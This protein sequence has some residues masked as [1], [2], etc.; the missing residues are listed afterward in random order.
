MSPPG[1]TSRSGRRAQAS[2][3]FWYQLSFASRPNK[4]L[5][6]RVAFGS[7]P[8]EAR[9]PQSPEKHPILNAFLYHPIITV[10]QIHSG[11]KILGPHWKTD[12]FIH[13]KRKVLACKEPF[14]NQINTFWTLLM[15][16]SDV[17]AFTEAQDAYWI[18]FKSCGV[19]VNKGNK[20][21]TNFNSH[22]HYIV[23]LLRKAKS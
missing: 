3:T 9:K 16:Q 22:F 17:L 8:A 11:P 7:R 20:P 13:S 4:M 23:V 6:L 14:L 12:I 10:I 21:N 1:R 15:W 2:T 18:I 5:S 19:D